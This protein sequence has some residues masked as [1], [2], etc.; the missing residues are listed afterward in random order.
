MIREVILGAGGMYLIILIAQ[1]IQRPSVGLEA[2][3]AGSV[4]AVAMGVY[5]SAYQHRIHAGESVAVWTGVLLFLVYGLF[6]YLTG[7]P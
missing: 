2:I 5:L 3:L 6:K 1:I 4:L 7:A